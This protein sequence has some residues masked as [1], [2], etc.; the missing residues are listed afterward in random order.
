M[1]AQALQYLDGVSKD[2]MCHHG[3]ANEHHATDQA[4]MDEV[5][6]SQ[7]QGA[8][9]NSQA[10]LEVHSLQHAPNEQQDVD[11]IQRVVPGQLVDQVLQLG[12][13]CLQLEKENAILIELQEGRLRLQVRVDIIPAGS[14]QMWYQ[15]AGRQKKCKERQVLCCEAAGNGTQHCQIMQRCSQSRAIVCYLLLMFWGPSKERTLCRLIWAKYRL[16][17]HCSSTAGV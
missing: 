17:M 9:H 13:G 14:T 3:V 16:S 1:R 10:R 15:L 2:Q 8:R 6:T 12:K 7:G 4:E 11:A 5:R